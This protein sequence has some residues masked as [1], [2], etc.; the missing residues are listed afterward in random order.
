MSKHFKYIYS[1]LQE[2]FPPISKTVESTTS[3]ASVASVA[4][5][6]STASSASSTATSTM[7][8]ST[9]MDLLSFNN[10][11]ISTTLTTS[12]DIPTILQND[13]SSGLSTGALVGIIVGVICFVLLC[14]GCLIL[15]CYKKHY[16]CFHNHFDKKAPQPK[17]SNIDA[18]SLEQIA[19]EISKN[20]PNA[21]ISPIRIGFTP[22]PEADMSKGRSKQPYSKTTII[23]SGSSRHSNQFRTSSSRADSRHDDS[24]DDFRN[25]KQSFSLHTGHILLYK[26]QQQQQQNTRKNPAQ[27]N[28]EQQEHDDGV[29][30]KQVQVKQH[31]DTCQYFNEN[32]KPRVANS[33]NNTNC[34]C[35][36]TV[37]YT[38]NSNS[39]RDDV[40][41]GAME[42]Q[43][44]VQVEKENHVVVHSEADH[45]H[46]HRVDVDVEVGGVVINMD[47]ID[48]NEISIDD[49]DADGS[50]LNIVSPSRHQHQHYQHQHQ[51]SHQ[52]HQSLT[53]LSFDS[54]DMTKHSFNSNGDDITGNR[55]SSNRGKVSALALRY[56]QSMSQ[57]NSC[58]PSRPTS[59]PAS[60]TNSRHNSFRDS[61][62]S[63]RNTRQD[64]YTGPTI[65][66][67]VTAIGHITDDEL[68]ARQSSTRS[69]NNNTSGSNTG[70]GE[71]VVLGIVCPASIVVT[72]VQGY[73]A[74]T[75][76][77]IDS[78][79]NMT[80]RNTS[81]SASTTSSLNANSAGQNNNSIKSN[82]APQYLSQRD[83]NGNSSSNSTTTVSPTATV[84]SLPQPT[85][86][87]PPPPV[88]VNG[89]R[90][91][92]PPPPP[93]SASMLLLSSSSSSSSALPPLPPLPT[94]RQV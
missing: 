33:T 35:P 64:M 8:N 27:F 77:E 7:I 87:L 67:T 93:P 92:L 45:D 72:G 12:G 43:V 46:H 58:H 3:V 94:N 44:Q 9:V 5:A 32:S 34:T 81:T 2:S 6:S 57:S 24:Y 17:T 80:K 10:S 51:P 14:I 56:S 49:T 15:L 19:L 23:S 59:V 20:D 54:A 22:L 71:A 11:S 68:L 48:Y 75:V 82:T 40:R 47:N 88:N 38:Q 73:S 84:T 4:S 18:E 85:N 1:T 91:S 69:S 55:S 76:I 31:R 66:T 39:R 21:V 78:D 90:L 37:Q 70:Q 26:Q 42:A 60:T 50:G 52:S 79:G 16:C 61:G 28:T 29:I 36:F 89:G 83:G 25:S 74:P 65:T 62:K 86:A 41:N 53:N 30:M 63:G 13:V